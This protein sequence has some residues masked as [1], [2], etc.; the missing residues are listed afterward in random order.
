M[1]E[2]PIAPDTTQHAREAYVPQRERHGVALALSGGGSRAALFHLGVLRRL[3][4]VGVLSRVDTISSVSGGSILAAHLAA[5]LRPW[6]A[7]GTTFADFESRVVAPFERFAQ[8]N[9]RTAPVARR[10]LFPWNWFRDTTQIEALVRLFDRYLNGSRLA[11]LPGPPDGPEF[12]FCASDNAFGV[13]WEMTRT[14]VGSYLS[15]HAP[16]PATWTVG[17]AV[18]ASSCFPPVFDPMPAGIDPADYRGYGGPTARREEL[19]RGLRLSDGG[20]YDN[21]ALE[22]VWKDR[23]VVIAS[24]GGGTLDP[25]ADVGP[26]WRIKRYAAIMGR[27]ATAIRKRWLI[28]GFI[29]ETMSGAYVGIA[30]DVSSYET[31]GPGYGHDLVDDVIS[32]VRTDLDAFTVP[33]IRVLQNHG[34]LLAEAAARQH[35]SKALPVADVPLRIPYPD[36]MD[37]AKVREWLKESHKVRLPFGRGSWIRY[38]AGG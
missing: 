12:I 22:P 18:A 7:P 6:P 3:N 32:E 31:G 16:T 35:L 26:L 15:G 33:E 24:D 9:L 17:R 21:L 25:D 11:E 5:T 4:E 20:L 37:E 34:Y 23:A 38:L 8:R 36:E 10:I 1:N 19:L 2:P 30:S 14:K 13:N 29:G 27:Q 28:A